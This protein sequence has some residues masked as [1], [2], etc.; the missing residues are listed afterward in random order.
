M[1]IL[2]FMKNMVTLLIV[3][4]LFAY[5]CINWSFRVE[6]DPLRIV[7]TNKPKD[8]EFE[9]WRFRLFRITK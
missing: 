3:E 4:L 8:L 5:C 7:D 6:F 1:R 9:L 2:N